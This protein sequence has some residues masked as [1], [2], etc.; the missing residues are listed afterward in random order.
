MQKKTTVINKR[1]KEDTDLM[2]ENKTR[3]KEKNMH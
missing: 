3:N 2:P 1:I